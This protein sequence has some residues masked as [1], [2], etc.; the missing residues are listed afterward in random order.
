MNL[1]LK[2]LPAKLLPLLD[3]FKKYRIVMFIVALALIFGFLIIKI[4]GYAQIEPTDDAVTEKL[5]TVQRP[6]IDENALTKIQ[7]LEDQNIEVQSLFQKARDNPFS[8]DE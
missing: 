7:Q 2:Q 1:D 3:K 5:T 8:E 6:K 4:N